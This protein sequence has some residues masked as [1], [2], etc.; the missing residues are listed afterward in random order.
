MDVAPLVIVILITFFCMANLPA[1]Q[2]FQK[3]Y[4]FNFTGRS[5]YCSDKI[6]YHAPYS[7]SSLLM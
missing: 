4:D 1:T 2:S 5:K 7:G 3:R 6:V